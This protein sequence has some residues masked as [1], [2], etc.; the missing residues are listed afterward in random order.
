M[1]LKEAARERRTGAQ[2]PVS[3]KVYDNT[4][5]TKVS[6]KKFLSHSST[7]DQLTSY[8]AQK[9]KEEYTNSQQVVIISYKETVVSNGLDVDH[10]QSSHEEAD[11]KL[12]LHARDATIRGATELDIQSPDTDVFLLAIR[13]FPLLPLATKFITGTGPS[14]RTIPL[15]PIYDCLGEVAASALPG[16]HAF[17]GADQTGRF[18]GKGKLTCW[19]T[20]MA[21]DDE[22]K[23]AFARLGTDLE[24]TE[25]M[26]NKLE[27]YVC[28]LYEPGTVLTSVAE[29]R[30]KL[31]C[32]KQAE[33]E[34]LP[35]TRGALLQMIL[36]AHYQ[37]MIWEADII[38]MPELPS[39]SDYGW[40]IDG[41]SFVP[42]PTTEPPAPQ[43]VVELVKCT[44]VKTHCESCSC[45]KHNMFCTEMC[46]CAAGDN[47]CQNIIE[48][49]LGS[50]LEGLGDEEFEISD[51]L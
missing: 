29:L 11:T 46:S 12:F 2:T 9:V 51:V 17:T 44:C 50:V 3:Y 38:A 41:G 31:F 48:N 7:K 49:S 28:L 14:R 24:P 13:R 21:A 8:L 42:V 33:G 43:A 27:Q 45:K 26:K 4:P 30:W 40:K 15:K 25:D 36:R 20:F 37:A 23:H 5:I 6:M 47:I 18:A 32:K 34:R 16:F 35:P 10:L 19:K 22:V 39:P 1:S